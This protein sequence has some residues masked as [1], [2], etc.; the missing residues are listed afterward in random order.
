MEKWNL[1]AFET[2][3][4]AFYK[5]SSLLQDTTKTS[6]KDHLCPTLRQILG[7]GN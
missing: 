5:A 2:M 6:D 4:L 7:G 1:T 3:E